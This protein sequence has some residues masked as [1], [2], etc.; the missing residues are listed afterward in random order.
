MNEHQVN[1]LMVVMKALAA[2]QL[3]QAEAINRLAQADETLVSLIA[4]TLV[5]EIDDELPPQT[6]LDGKPR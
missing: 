4:K 5:D 1:E 6:Y 2:S 3:K